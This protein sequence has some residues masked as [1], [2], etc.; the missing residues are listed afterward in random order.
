MVYNEEN[1]A[2]SENSNFLYIHVKRFYVQKI[3]KN[4]IEM[5]KRIIHSLMHY[6]VALASLSC[7]FKSFGTLTDIKLHFT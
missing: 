3:W 2:F 7:N 1:T 6:G 5:S 4:L